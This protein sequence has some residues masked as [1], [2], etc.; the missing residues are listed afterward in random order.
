MVNGV[1]GDLG[2]V[3][4]HVMVEYR[5]IPECVTIPNLHV[6]EKSVKGLASILSRNVMTIF[7]QVRLYQLSFAIATYVHTYVQ[8]LL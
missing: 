5:T 6:E 2:H 3:V 8:Y 7:A 4:R 1:N